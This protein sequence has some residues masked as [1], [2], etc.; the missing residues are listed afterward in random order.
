MLCS[1]H[2]SIHLQACLLYTCR[3][4]F[5]CNI[6]ALIIRIGFGGPTVLYYDK[7]PPKIVLVIIKTAIVVRGGVDPATCFPLR[8]QW[9]YTPMPRLLHVNVSI[10]MTQSQAHVPLVCFLDEHIS[11]SVQ[12]PWREK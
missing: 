5:R 7:E 3:A 11:G 2:Y 10:Y 8:N 1:V 12:R 6:G 4:H 9:R